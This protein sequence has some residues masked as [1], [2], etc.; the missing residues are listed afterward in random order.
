MVSKDIKVDEAVVWNWEKNEIKVEDV[1]QIGV[2]I[3]Q[4]PEEMKMKS[5]HVMMKLLKKM[6]RG[7]M[8]EELKMIKKNGTWELARLVIKGYSQEY[9]VDFSN[10][11]APVA[12]HDTIR[13][14][15]ALAAKMGW[16]IHH[17][18]VKSAFQMVC[19]KKIFMLSNQ[20]DFKFQVVKTKFTSSA[21]LSM[22]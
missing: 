3:P 16:K 10:T 21:K 2:T 1:D 15:V 4:I 7:S 8:E 20:K 5:L 13:L 22:A 17:L 14:L 9:G 6:G 18:D 12:R 11:F 19:L